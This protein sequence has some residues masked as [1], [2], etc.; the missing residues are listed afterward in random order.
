MLKVSANVKC[1]K[2]DKLDKCI[3]ESVPIEKGSGGVW[4]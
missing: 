3:I 1:E 4:G 2:Y